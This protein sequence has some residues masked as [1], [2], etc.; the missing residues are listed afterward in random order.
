MTYGERRA[1]CACMTEGPAPGVRLP[2]AL[3][4]RIPDVTDP[5]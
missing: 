4:V 1:P 2:A 5:C 3:P